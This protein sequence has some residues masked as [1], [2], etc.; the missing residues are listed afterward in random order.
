MADN[1]KTMTNFQ[2]LTEKEQ[3]IIAQ[4]RT[5]YQAQNRIPCTVC[6]YCTEVCPAGI[7]IPDIFSALN[8]KRQEKEGADEAYAAFEVKA[9]AC[10]ECGRCEEECPQHL[11]IREL[12][13]E[14]HK[15]FA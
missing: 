15:A 1:L 13:K 8:D 5:I 2:P 11:H 7:P 3:E 9:D 12:L 14:A 4:V 6:R 10:L